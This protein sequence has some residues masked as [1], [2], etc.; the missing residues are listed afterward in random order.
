[1]IQ[2]LK[3]VNFQSHEDSFLEFSEGVNVIVGT[4]DSGKSS[5]LRSI[6]WL[7]EN[8]PLGIDSIKN[9][10]SA[11]DV[12][13]EIIN[14][15]F[16]V[17]R[18]KG[19]TDEYR[20]S[21]IQDP[22]MAFGQSV[23]EEIKKALNIQSINFQKQIDAPFLFSNSPGFVAEHFNKM[24]NIH[25]TDKSIQYI[26]SELSK[27]TS[28]I[29]KPALKNVKATGLYKDIEKWNSQLIEFDNLE[30]IEI[31]LEVLEQMVGDSSVLKSR[32]LKLEKLIKDISASEKVIR[33]SQ[34]FLDLELDVAR[35]SGMVESRK[36]AEK[37][38]T[39]LGDLLWG[40]EVRQASI[41][42]FSQS[43]SYTGEVDD[44]LQL[45]EKKD[46]IQKDFNKLKSD[47]YNIKEIQQ[48]IQESKKTLLELEKE[49]HENMP[50]V[51]P[52]CGK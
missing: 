44:L 21:G 19:K 42:K 38:I 1:M 28:I 36:D 12:E 5:I 18:V 39:D 9:W 48:N 24:C 32:T 33:D 30:H 6:F 10:K 43:L 25:V 34:A 13:V 46:T 23:P 4:T 49:W 37:S 3:L 20:L 47:L 31:E 45:L 50:D 27:L 51:C 15:N 2:S 22:F 14:D 26:N 11:G 29:G 35:L 17:G 7:N 41:E 52:L 16:T 40:I 8:R